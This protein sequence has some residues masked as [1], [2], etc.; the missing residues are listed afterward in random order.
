MK[1][2]L[3]KNGISVTETTARIQNSSSVETSKW[4]H[5]VACD[6]VYCAVKYI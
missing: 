6:V 5:F 4:S 3:L 1:L 2:W